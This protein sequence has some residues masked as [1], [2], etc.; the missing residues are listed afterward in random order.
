MYADSMAEAGLGVLAVTE[1][2]LLAVSAFVFPARILGAA[3]LGASTL[4]LLMALDLSDEPPTGNTGLLVLATEF[5]VFAGAGKPA[6]NAGMAAIDVSARVATALGVAIA[7]V[8]VLAWLLTPMDFAIGSFAALNPSMAFCNLSPPIRNTNSGR[9]I[10]KATELKIRVRR[11]LKA[12]G[13]F[14]LAPAKTAA[15]VSA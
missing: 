4:G 10:N 1:R 15:A 3:D 5:G 11:C 13:F 14:C 8:G 6:A 2:L 9:A 12:L 7:A